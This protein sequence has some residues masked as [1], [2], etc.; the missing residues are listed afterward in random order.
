MSLRPDDLHLYYPELWEK[1]GK[2]FGAK[3]VTEQLL[4]VDLNEDAVDDFF[5]PL[6]EARLKQEVISQC[7]PPISC[8]C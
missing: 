6:L 2:V 3:V 5:T 7:K 4:K 1:F 8:Q